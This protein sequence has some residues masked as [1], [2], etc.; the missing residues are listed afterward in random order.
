MSIHE[1]INGKVSSKRAWARK[2]L[3]TALSIVWIYTLLWGYTTLRELTPPDMP[4]ALIQMWFGLAGGGLT[5][6][7]LTLGETKK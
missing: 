7:G 3:W 6:L 2:L 5:A 4:D 1:D